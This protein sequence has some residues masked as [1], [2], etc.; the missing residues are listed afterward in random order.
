[1]FKRCYSFRHALRA[2][3]LP[4]EEGYPCRF[5]AVLFD[6]GLMAEPQWIRGAFEDG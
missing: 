5:D 4:Q 6:N 3:H 1:V 2:C